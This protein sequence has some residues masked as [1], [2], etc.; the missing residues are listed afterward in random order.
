[1]KWTDDKIS[2]L[3]P[4]ASTDRRGKMLAN[5]IKWDN[6]GTN[7]IAIWGDCIPIESQRYLVQINLSDSSFKCSCT[8]RNT[9]CKHILGLLYMYSKSTALFKYQ[10][11]PPLINN[12]LSS[13]T[14]TLAKSK[15]YKKNN[16]TKIELEKI[17]IAKEKRW[18]KRLKLMSDGID[19]LELW[20]TDLVRHG[21]ANI[22]ATKSDFWQQVAAKMIDA[23]LPAIST[24]LKETHQ[25]ILQEKEWAKL[26]VS[27]IGT[28]YFWVESFKKRESF[29]KL[30]QNELYISLGKTIKKSTILES[31][32]RTTDIWLVMGKKEGI[33]I[34][35]TNY[36]RVWL[37]GQKTGKNALI[38]DYI[39]GKIS[40]EQQ[41]NVGTLLKGTL[42]YF[43][44][45]YNQRA[46]FANFELTNEENLNINKYRNVSDFFDNYSEA[47]AQN[48]WI[49]LFPATL[50][51]ISV[52][53]NNNKELII[54]DIKGQ[55]MPIA[56]ISE[57][58]QWKLLAVSGGHPISLFGEWNGIYFEPISIID[59]S[60]ITNL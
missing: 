34:E 39:F 1:M 60:I 58:A 33:D 57:S 25:I 20:L 14:K 2:A 29:D 28:L 40:Y 59:N 35:G 31:H 55:L 52:F 15:S 32:P 7:Y 51:N 16:K 43:S 46:I 17:K 45:N 48:P 37:Y 24:Y 5:S 44:S 19:E 6:L 36:R 9:V 13:D 56:K 50:A 38:I 23:K 12:W 11:P 53:M 47:T 54:K 18:Q 22:N 27:R 42:A 26:I 3:A 4:N 8:V 49:R 21:I 10:P 41:Y 30:L